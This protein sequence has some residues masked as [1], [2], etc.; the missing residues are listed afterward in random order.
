MFRPIF[1]TTH[2]TGK[3]DHV[4]KHICSFL[5]YLI[6]YAFQLLSRKLYITDDNDIR[7]HAIQEHN[8][9]T[10]TEFNLVTA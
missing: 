3:S 6:H 9:R 2:T 8:E 1:K 10:S 4:Y 5:C 7:P